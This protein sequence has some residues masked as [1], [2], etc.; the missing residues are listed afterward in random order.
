MNTMPHDFG[1][2]AVRLHVLHA[3]YMQQVASCLALLLD[4]LIFR[5]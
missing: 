2:K 3:V 5:T 1:G 4:L